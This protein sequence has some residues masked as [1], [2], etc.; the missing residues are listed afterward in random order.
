MKLLKMKLLKNVVLYV[1]FV[2]LLVQILGCSYSTY[3]F[4]KNSY[5]GGV[6][7]GGKKDQDLNASLI[8]ANCA[9]RQIIFKTIFNSDFIGKLKIVKVGDRTDTIRLFQV[10]VVNQLNSSVAYR[11]SK[12]GENVGHG[13][14]KGIDEK[15]DELRALKLRYAKSTRVYSVVDT[16]WLPYARGYKIEYSSSS[17]GTQIVYLDINLRPGKV[18]NDFLG[19]NFIRFRYK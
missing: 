17:S 12:D 4:R 13:L 16:L 6:I 8:E 7:R 1:V 14:I 18:F 3:A 9:I 10:F 2:F 5:N 15:N 11:V 19:H